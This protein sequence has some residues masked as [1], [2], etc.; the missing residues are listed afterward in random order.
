MI[1]FLNDSNCSVPLSPLPGAAGC[2][3]TAA[4]PQGSAELKAAAGSVWALLTKTEL[5]TAPLNCQDL[6]G[7]SQGQGCKRAK[8]SCS[9]WGNTQGSGE[10]KSPTAD[11]Q[12]CN[13]QAATVPSASQCL[14]KRESCCRV[15][16][17]GLI[18][19]SPVLPF[20]W[21]FGFK[22]GAKKS[23][24]C[25]GTSVSTRWANRNDSSHFWP[26]W[27]LQRFLVSNSFF[28]KQ[29]RKASQD[30]SST[31][32]KPSSTPWGSVKLGIEVDTDFWMA[33]KLFRA[34]VPLFLVHGF[35]TR[36]RTSW[37]IAQNHTR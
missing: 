34:L 17:W 12:N 5:S 2:Q 1:L 15:N 18:C 36:F 6:H 16:P 27:D 22:T 25:L 35:I 33:H 13:L 11:G 14:Q 31:D 20:E 8:C 30:V 7:V 29:P 9:R 10:N 4:A 21:S 19:S 24:I 28:S 3:L 37:G 23:K 26:I 32:L